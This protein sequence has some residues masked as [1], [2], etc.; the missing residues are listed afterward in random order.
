MFLELNLN[1]KGNERDESEWYL[2][3]YS[4][5]KSIDTHSPRKDKSRH[6]SSSSKSATLVTA[7][8]NG[9][10]TQRKVDFLFHNNEIENLPFFV[11]DHRC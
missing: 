4:T 10:Q 1:F 8:N 9:D 11:F 6:A 3:N 5:T 2:N 7:F